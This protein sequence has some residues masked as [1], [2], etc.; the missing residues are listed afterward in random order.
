MSSKEYNIADPSIIIQYLSDK[1][2]SQ[3]GASVVREYIANALDAHRVADQ[4]KKIEVTIVSPK[5]Y[6]P[7]SLKIRDYGLGLSEEEFF[8]YFAGYGASGKDATDKSIG[9]FG[10]GCKSAFALVTS[11]FVRSYYEGYLTEYH[12]QITNS[13][14]DI[15]KLYSNPTTEVNGLEIFI[16]SIPYNYSSEITQTISQ[17]TGYNPSSIDFYS[18]TNHMV[19]KPD[20]KVEDLTYHNE[21]G[22]F[23]D[24]DIIY[25]T[26]AVAHVLVGGIPYSIQN[27]KF[28]FTITKANTL[29][30]LDAKDLDFTISREQFE[31]TQKTRKALANAWE[32]VWNPYKTIIDKAFATVD[33]KESALKFWEQHIGDTGAAY[34]TSLLQKFLAPISSRIRCSLSASR[35]QSAVENSEKISLLLT[36]NKQITQKIRKAIDLWTL[37]NATI[38]EDKTT[39]IHP[40]Y[41]ILT[42]NPTI[43]E[44]SKQFV[45]KVVDLDEYKKKVPKVKQ[46]SIK[47][48]KSY[49]VRSK[50][51]GP[52]DLRI[53]TSELN[54]YFL[55][56]SYD[57]LSAEFSKSNVSELFG[58]KKKIVFQSRSNQLQEKSRN[59]RAELKDLVKS[60]LENKVFDIKIVPDSVKKSVQDYSIAYS[61]LKSYF[62]K[63]QD[64]TRE[65]LI[66]SIPPDSMFADDDTLRK[67][68]LQI[69]GIVGVKPVFNLIQ[70]NSHPKLEEAKSLIHE[71][72]EINVLYIPYNFKPPKFFQDHLVGL[73]DRWQE[74]EIHA[75]KKE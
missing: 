25:R 47:G 8:Y 19:C 48:E 21:F 62:A 75:E 30:L 50:R 41:I 26:G 27:E 34:P 49:C 35:L 11:F 17:I 6:E 36:K 56:D 72:H 58:L 63:T 66:R 42:Q 23:K 29:L 39:I 32:Q 38:G 73:Y 10:L 65:K 31:D 54:N 74:L 24:Y 68:L 69:G 71:I 55:I 59:D 60:T 5:A 1:I 14:A 40:K 51:F 2:Y 64:K 7:F 9:K 16:P 61:L 70:E 45:K 13:S 53:I 33:S 22:G 46:N 28:G 43:D 67:I 20:I 15:K 57:S 18:N 52:V 44:L 3:K 37:E 4:S 12:C